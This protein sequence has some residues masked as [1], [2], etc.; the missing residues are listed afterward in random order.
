MKKMLSTILVLVLLV[1]MGINASAAD[2][3]GNGGSESKNVLITTDKEDT[4]VVYSVA[5][6]W[7]SDMTF[8]YEYGN[9]GIWQPGSHS[10][11]GDK[12][13]PGWTNGSETITVTNH[14][15]APIQYNVSYVAETEDYSVAIRFEGN[16]ASDQESLSNVQIP[17]AEGKAV[18][19]AEL[20]S[21]FKV[22]ATTPPNQENLQG[23]KIG[24]V[25]V[26]ISA[27]N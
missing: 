14:S 2:S 21:T 3:L 15:N 24:T 12:V 8:T 13:E 23:V 7:T 26:S 6:S 18:D 4:G 25:T 10:Y 9:K 20:I 17:S 5:I 11:A 27:V 16:N 22:N 19:A 1:A